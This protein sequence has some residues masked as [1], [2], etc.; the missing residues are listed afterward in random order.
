MNIIFSISDILTASVSMF[1]I[2]LSLFYIFRGLSRCVKDPHY[3]KKFSKALVAWFKKSTSSLDQK[4]RVVLKDYE[5]ANAEIGRRDNIGLLI[6]T[7]LVTSSFLILG[8]AIKEKPINIGVYAFASM[9]LFLVFLL[10][11]HGTTE[12]LD[13]ISYRRVKAIEQ[14]LTDFFKE[15]LK[16]S[17]K[18]EIKNFD[19]GIHSYIFERT[20]TAER[21]RAKIWLRIRRVFWDVVLLLLSLAWLSLAITIQVI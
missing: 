12:K 6:G 4:L 2:V 19:F 14:A 20:L 18:E 1:G 15:D 17:N 11:L 8:S 9:G 5:T 21:N 10:I 13:S 7:I 16:K 3:D